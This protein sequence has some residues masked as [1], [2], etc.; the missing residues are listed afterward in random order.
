MVQ[1]E[2]PAHIESTLREQ[3]KDLPRAVL[4]AVAIEGYREGILSLGQVGAVLGIE[5]IWDV[6]AFLAD[7]KV[8]IPY[9]EQDLDEDT[10][11]AARLAPQP[12]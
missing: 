8:G 9:T 4:E 3:W 10:R 6:R 5:S 2:L 7:R 11:A 12:R 1:I